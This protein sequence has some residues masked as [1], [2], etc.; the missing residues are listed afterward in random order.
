VTEGHHLRRRPNAIFTAL[1]V[2]TGSKGISGK[3]ANYYYRRAKV[4]RLISGS[5]QAGVTVKEM[6]AK[7]E[8]FR[9]KVQEG[10]RKPGK[11]PQ[12]KRETIG[13]WVDTTGLDL[14]WKQHLH[15][16]R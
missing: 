11:Q 4:V 7:V 5:M 15:D 13:A 16:T 10:N 12:T 6:C 1:A 3:S 2:I 8:S 9:L 14:L